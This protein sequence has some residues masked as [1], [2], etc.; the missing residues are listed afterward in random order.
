VSLFATGTG[1][2]DSSNLPQLPLTVGINN[3]GAAIASVLGIPG[4]MGALQ[5]NVQVSS[6]V[7]SGIMVPVVIEVGGIFS[8]VV[9]MAI[10]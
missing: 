8:Q 1:L 7:P 4:V 10:Q 3:E 5:I 2:A 6:D 9:T